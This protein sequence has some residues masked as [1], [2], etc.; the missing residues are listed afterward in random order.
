MGG[1]RGLG[2]VLNRANKS[3]TTNPKISFELKKKQHQN[4]IDPHSSKKFLWNEIHSP[5]IL[6]KAHTRVDVARLY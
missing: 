4:Y 1:M 3:S 5:D 2:N 6:D